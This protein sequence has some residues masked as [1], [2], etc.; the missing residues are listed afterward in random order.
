MNRN[1]FL[2]AVREKLKG[3]S[4]EDIN[5]ALEFYEEAISDR[6]EEGLT[7][8]QAVA[9]IGTPD[10]IANQIMMD[11][12][13]PKLMKAQAK[14]KPKKSFKAWEIVLLVL[15]FPLWFPLVLTAGI[16]ALTFVIVLAVLVIAFFI[17]VAALGFAGI[18][19]LVASIT[20]LIMG[21]GTAIVMQMGVAVFAMGL[22]ML[23]FFPAKALTVW[24]IELVGKF[25]KWI[26]G[27]IISRK[28]KEA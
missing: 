3:L 2:Q 8:D 23:L 5:K 16:L 13:L 14:A 26:K 28:N 20:A 12:P 10:E 21:G 7:E 11:M 4:E 25:S 6:M 19:T 22:A 15:G 24:M 17:I 9:A 27:K 18:V 1:D